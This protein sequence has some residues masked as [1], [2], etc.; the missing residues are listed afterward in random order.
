MKYD[1]RKKIGEQTAK[2]K[3]VSKRKTQVIRTTTAKGKKI[4]YS[5]YFKKKISPKIVNAPTKTI[6]CSD[7]PV[8]L[9]RTDKEVSRMYHVIAWQTELV[10]YEVNDVY[11][12]TIEL[13]PKL[14]CILENIGKI[15]K[16]FPLYGKS[17]HVIGGVKF[18][19]SKYKLG[20]Q[21]TYGYNWVFTRATN[22]PY[23]RKQFLHMLNKVKGDFKDGYTII[24]VESVYIKIFT[25][26]VTPEM[27]DW[28]IRSGVRD[29]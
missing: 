19:S 23:M 7:V 1:S 6:I 16:K 17:P 11:V 20:T 8:W 15:L 4:I 14:D 22:T 25:N 28:G 29:L 9:Y 12:Q 24:K 3:E 13:L 5:P 18:I 26:I 21:S 10:F 2:I 27:Q